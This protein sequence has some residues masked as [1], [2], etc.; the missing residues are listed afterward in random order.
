MI[1]AQLSMVRA[2]STAEAVA[3]ITVD[4]AFHAGGTELL[5]WMRL[6]ISEP[7]LLVD[8]GQVEALRGIA[9]SHDSLRIGARATLNE[10]GQNDE[11]RKNAPALSQA[12]LKA[13][14]P[15]IR[16]RATIGGNILQ[17]T[18]C[19]W[20]RA[21]APGQT[22]MP[23]PCNKR[24]PGSGCA[25]RESKF[26]KLAL[27]GASEECAATQP[28]DPAVALSALDAIVEV[29]GREGARLIPMTEF[30]LTQSE[31]GSAVTETTLRQGELVTGFRIPIDA[32]AQRSAYL[33]VRERESFEY[34]MVSCA[35]A[36]RLEGEI[37]RA[38]R[39]SLGSVAQKPW[40]LRQAEKELLDVRLSTGAV[41][42][43]LVRD[44]S[45]ARP[46]PGNEFK[47]LLAGNA[48]RRALQ[49]A[50]ERS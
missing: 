5:N 48:V 44:L 31:A 33:K 27:Y 11:V 49:I 26:S 20:F 32:A 12:C 40:R 4:A 22:A 42:A 14:S 23:W 25:A 43:A 47:P 18:R 37:V 46:L 34:A 17:K 29:S 39:I 50:G 3:A 7:A 21:E 45:E 16:N 8:L 1:D 41:D 2:S 38:I 28:S 19:P 30:H 35:V 24:M 36:L 10:I 9:R 13:A 15:Q 6:G